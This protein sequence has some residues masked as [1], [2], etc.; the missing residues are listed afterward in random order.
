MDDNGGPCGGLTARTTGE[1]T[2][3]MEN[4][5]E[6]YQFITTYLHQL[7]IEAG[8]KMQCYRPSHPEKGE[9]W[10]QSDFVE[11]KFIQVSEVKVVYLLK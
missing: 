4:W 11:C 1:H 7:Q 8:R 10:A 6:K 3:K 9:I 2:Q 5:Y